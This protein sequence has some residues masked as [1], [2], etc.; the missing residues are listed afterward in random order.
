MGF[1]FGFLMFICSYL[2]VGPIMLGAYVLQNSKAKEQIEEKTKA[3]LIC[4]GLYI[5]VWV[6][7]LCVDTIFNYIGWVITG[8]II[9]VICA[10]ITYDK[11][12]KQAV[13]NEDKHKSATVSTKAQGTN[14]LLNEIL[15]QIGRNGI[16]YIDPETELPY[17]ALIIHYFNK[18]EI[19]NV[20]RAYKPNL[21]IRFNCDGVESGLLE[22]AAEDEK[23]DIFKLLI[24]NGVRCKNYNQ[25]LL[26]I[27]NTNNYNNLKCL[28]DFRVVD[29][30]IPISKHNLSVM[31]DLF[32]GQTI[33]DYALANNAHEYIINLIKQN[34]GKCILDIEEGKEHIEKVGNV[35]YDHR[36]EDSNQSNIGKLLNGL[37]DVETRIHNVWG[38]GKDL[39]SK[40]ELVE[41]AINL[42]S[43]KDKLSKELYDKALA[44]YLEYQSNEY[45]TVNEYNLLAMQLEIKLIQIEFSELINRE[46]TSSGDVV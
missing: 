33:L 17:M 41:F 2:M 4:L 35:D 9:G 20:I 32:A 15:K 40:S 10:Y 29:F 30:N 42:K 22:I 27:I 23:E 8:A 45:K 12:K 18:R 7:V 28:V 6:V 38:G 1:L 43:F 46:I 16:D 21:N 13:I 26:S 5:V 31:P 39:F 14:E 34:G 25:V 37:Q 19:E 11:N 36:S 24:Q 3:L 44:R